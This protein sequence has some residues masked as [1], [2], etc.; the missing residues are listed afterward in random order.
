[1]IA[2][3]HAQAARQLGF[4][5]VAVAS[6]TAERAAS[7]ASELGC[8]AVPFA[9]L[10]AGADIVVVATPPPQ[11]FDH[12][13]HALER[14]ATVL[15]EK[16]VTTTLNEVDRLITMA[17]RLGHR[18]LYAENLVFAPSV[19]AFLAE[20]PDSGAV[21]HLSLRTVQPAPQW[22]DFLQPSAGGGVLFDLGVHPLA[23]AV[24]IGRRCGAGEIV[25]VRA[26]LTGDV[27]DTDARVELTYANGLTASV[28]ASWE[29][30]NGPDWDVQMAGASS[31]LR[32]EIFPNVSLERNGDPVRLP[33]TTGPHPWL[34]HLGYLDQMRVAATLASRSMES[35]CDLRFGRWVLEIV[36]ACYVSAGRSGERVSVPSGCDRTLTPHHLWNPN[37][38]P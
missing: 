6:R 2:G 17:D 28:H 19:R 27:V 8:R 21:Q 12:V 20:V 24:L 36:C 14:H 25:E 22:G 23:L 4:P 11:H 29:G 37:F 3:V 26:T 9:H 18:V 33:P 32:L 5:I 30:R 31:A 16:P 35:P 1:M 13:A 10:P 7:R 38:R 34:E 15:V